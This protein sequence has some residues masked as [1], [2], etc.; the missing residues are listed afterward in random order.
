MEEPVFDKEFYVFLTF[1]MDQLAKVIRHRSKVPEL[2]SDLLTTNEH[3][4]LQS[5]ENLQMFEQWGTIAKCRWIFL[6]WSLS[7]LKKKF[8]EWIH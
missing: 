2:K 6:N 7:K 3:K 4:A 5:G 1:Y 8:R